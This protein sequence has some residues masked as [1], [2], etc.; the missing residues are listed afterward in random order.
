MFAMRVPSPPRH[1]LTE[2]ADGLKG[3]DMRAAALF[4]PDLV[5]ER[6]RIVRT[7]RSYLIPRLT[8]YGRPMTVVLT[9]PTGSGKSTILNSLLG[10]DLA[11]TGALRP[12]TKIPLVVTTAAHA[13]RFETLGA[14]PC[15]VA[16]TRTPILRRMALVDT[17]DIDSTSVEHRKM[18]ESL[19]DSADVV[20]FVTS[21][22]RYADRVPWEVLR[23]AV[24][25]GAP[26][27]SVLNRLSVSSS[28]A[29]FD[30]AARLGRAGIETEIVRVPEQRRGREGGRVPSLAVKELSH[31][32]HALADEM[33]EGRPAGMRVAATVLGDAIRLGEGLEGLARLVSRQQDQ[34]E[35]VVGRGRARV[36]LDG[37]L[38]DLPLPS[39]RGG[40]IRRLL[41]LSRPALPE[42]ALLHWLGLV[43]ARLAAVVETELRATTL[44]LE[45][46]LPAAP[47]GVVIEP[48]LVTMGTAIHGWLAHLRRV[49]EGMGRKDRHLATA[50]LVTRSLGSGDAATAQSVLGAR[51]AVVTESARTDLESRLSVTFSQLTMVASAQLEAVAGLGAVSGVQELITRANARLT[52]ADA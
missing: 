5:E 48:A 37:I 16:T 10:L 38:D 1:E 29:A 50:I 30:Y 18:A 21:A 12:T 36:E 24:D 41:R 23:R 32:L 15:H 7:I 51:E 13:R 40:R 33:D 27:I 14:V 42:P 46:L 44:E 19:I 43:S 3:L 47:G 11:E 31:R 35:A 39:P 28:G 25:R 22:L 20:V 4:A 49:T 52:F 8:E 17:P 45:S 2:L 34:I 6:D 26:V 9:G